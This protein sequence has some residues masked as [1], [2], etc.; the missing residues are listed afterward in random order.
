MSVKRY[1]KR[2]FD[3]EWKVNHIEEDRGSLGI[4]M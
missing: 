3:Q 2:R 1:L 4:S